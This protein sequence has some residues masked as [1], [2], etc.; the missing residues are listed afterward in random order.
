MSAQLLSFGEASGPVAR[1]RAEIARVGGL[2]MDFGSV[3]GKLERCLRWLDR[4]QIEVAAFSCSTFRGPM[5]Y[6]I[7]PGKLRQLL[8]DEM[9]S[10]GHVCSGG[11]RTEKWQAMDPST[12]VLICWEEEARA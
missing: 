6:A 3:L 1:R 8:R 11:L 2:Q 12:G 7:G 4:H 5:V 10:R 9:Y